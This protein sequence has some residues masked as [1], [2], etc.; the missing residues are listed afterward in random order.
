MRQVKRFAA[1]VAVVI[2]VAAGGGAAWTFVN[3][4]GVGQNALALQGNVDVRQ[5]NLSFKIGGRLAT[6]AVEEGDAITAGQIVATLDKSYFEDDLRQ[7][8]ARV[9]IQKAIVAK[10]ENGTRPEEIAQARAEVQVRSATLE[11]ARL[12]FA[13]QDELAGRG[14]APHQTH[15]NA[16]AALREAEA[17]LNSAQQALRLAEIGPRQEDIAAARAQ[18]E[19]EAAALTEAE[20][21]LTDAELPAP[22]AGTVLTRVREPGSIVAAGET[23]YA[24]SLASPVWARTYVAEPDLGRIRAGMRAEVRTDSGQIYR[25]QVGF[26]SPVAEFTPKSVETRELRTS[27]VYRVRVIV[28]NSDAGLKQGMPVTILLRLGGEG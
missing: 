17:Q 18:L 11:N 28:E 10:L 16:R 13:R 2:L 15:D 7:V 19:A 5:V 6:M 3:N 9:E 12:T 1:V 25:G 22:K 26:I 27:L 4:R 20:R 8:R 21:R 14:I 23:V 24:L